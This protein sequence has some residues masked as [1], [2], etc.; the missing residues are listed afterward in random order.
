[1]AD[2]SQRIRDMRTEKG[3]TLAELMREAA[4]LIDTMA[5]ALECAEEFIMNGVEFGMIR[6]PTS[7]DDEATKALPT[8]RSALAKARGTA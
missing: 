6:M 4:D 1:M 7:A 2:I 3:Q 8:I 5:L